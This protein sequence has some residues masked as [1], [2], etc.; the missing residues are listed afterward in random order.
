MEI[1]DKSLEKTTGGGDLIPGGKE[2]AANNPKCS[3]FEKRENIWP[4][5]VLPLQAF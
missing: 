1:D 4:H 5:V 3:K 2:V